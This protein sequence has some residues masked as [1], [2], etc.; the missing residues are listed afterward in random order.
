MGRFNHGNTWNQA[1]DRFPQPIA[2]GPRHLI[3]SCQHDDSCPAEARFG[4]PQ[5]A[6]REEA[7][8]SPRFS[9]IDQHHVEIAGQTP[10]LHAVIQD[11]DIAAQLLQ[12]GPGKGHAVGPLEMRHIEQVFLQNQGL[13]IE[14]T[15]D[16]GSRG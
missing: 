3:A 14:P 10:V 5:Q 4:F 1:V 11:Q 8:V 15:L 2:L 16:P 13:I 12:C 9:G 6:T 7:I